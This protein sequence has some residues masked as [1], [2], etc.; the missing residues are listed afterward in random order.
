MFDVKGLEKKNED[1]TPLEMVLSD[2]KANVK[3]TQLWNI[4]HID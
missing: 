2:S 1:E 4:G 3:I